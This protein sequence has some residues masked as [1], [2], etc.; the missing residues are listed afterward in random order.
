M[1]D[2]IHFIRSFL[3]TILTVFE[4]KYLGVTFRNG[5]NVF[6]K[7]DLIITRVF[8]FF[9]SQFDRSSLNIIL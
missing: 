6:V 2:C 8:S 5:M 4:K 7:Q 9:C 1:S 3:N